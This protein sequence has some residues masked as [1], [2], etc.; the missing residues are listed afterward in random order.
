MPIPQVEN[1]LEVVFQ[2][3]KVFENEA[4]NKLMHDIIAEA[5]EL[6]EEEIDEMENSRLSVLEYR[7]ARARAYLKA[8]NLIERDE[9]G[10]WILTD[11]GKVVNSI[12]EYKAL[13]SNARPANVYGTHTSADIGF[14]KDA[15]AK[16]SQS[17]QTYAAQESEEQQTEPTAVSRKQLAS[18]IKR[19]SPV[20]VKK[21]R[22]NFGLSQVFEAAKDIV[23]PSL[24]FYARPRR[25]D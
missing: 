23:F 18:P 21:Q 3:I 1:L 20:T 7:L 8:D 13:R 22:P 24:P 6:T 4:N 17:H 15:G 16:A 19:S 11:K 9:K 12:S 5:L 25:R 14:V 10:Y 2:T